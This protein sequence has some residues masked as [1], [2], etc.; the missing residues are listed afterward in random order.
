MS[1]QSTDATKPCPFCAETIKAAAIV[2]RFCGRELTLQAAPH[3][4]TDRELLT[5]AI[6][7]HTQAGWRITA[8]SD[9]G[10]QAILP[11]KWS[12]FLLACVLVFGLGGLLW[13]PLF[14]IAVIALLIAAAMYLSGSDTQRYVSV[15][16]LRQELANFQPN[17]A[18]VV[19][20]GSGG[21]TCSACGGG[22]RFE[23]TSCKH[24]SKPLMTPAETYI[25]NA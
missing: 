5:Q 23:A 19:S 15:G 13:L 25:N 22:V 7:N 4:P 6:A 21:Y 9:A 18:R 11:R 3:G 2:C 1:D 24:C 14:G 10:F 17:V 16:D 8:Q 20:N 12:P